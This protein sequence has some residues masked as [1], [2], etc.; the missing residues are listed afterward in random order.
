MGVTSQTHTFHSVFTCICVPELLSPL[1][2]PFVT[3]GQSK[4]VEIFCYKMS[5]SVKHVLKTHSNFPRITNAHPA[6]VFPPSLHHKRGNVWLN[7]AFLSSLYAPTPTFPV[8]TRPLPPF[9]YIS[10]LRQSHVVSLEIAD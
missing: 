2:C 7:N 3:N 8:S 9:K 1:Y 5:T 4:A 10:Y 6:T